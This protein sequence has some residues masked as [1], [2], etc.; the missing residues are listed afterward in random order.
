MTRWGTALSRYARRHPAASDL[1][2][3]L[4]DLGTDGLA[5]LLAAVPCLADAVEGRGPLSPS[6]PF[7]IRGSNPLDRN[8]LAR[9]L[10]TPP[11]TEFLVLSLDASALALAQLA[12]WHGGTL[13]RDLARDEIPTLDADQLD[14]V[15]G[16]LHDRLLTDRDAGWVALR[17]G[18]IDAIDLPGLPAA[19]ALRHVNSDVLADKLRVLG[20]PVPPRKAERIDAV[21][22]A[23]REPETI[24]RTVNRLPAAA[25]RAL[26]VLV[27]HG[28]Q[29]VE[30]LGEPHWPPY[31]YRH[32]RDSAIG[33]LLDR[34]LIGVD[35]DEQTCVVW[36]DVLVGLN[37]GRLF[38]AAFP[39]PAPAAPQAPLPGGP[40]ALPPVLEHLDTLLEHWRVRPAEALSGGGLGVRSVRA[41]AKS[42]GL[43]GPYVGLLAV[44]ATEIGLLGV[45]ERGST[46]RGRDRR[47]HRQWGPTSLVEQWTEQ[48]PAW[49]W[50][51][52]V[53]TWRRSPRV[54]E[55]D[56]LPE[57][58]EPQSVVTDATAVATRSAWL[59]HLA[60]LPDGQGVGAD[61]VAEAAAARFPM[62][63]GA[64]SRV[65]AMVA[66]TRVLGLVPADGPVGLTAAGRAVLDGPDAVEALLPA[67]DD[68][69]IV[70]ADLTIV[71][72]PGAP[73]DVTTA[74]ARWA[75]LE[76]AAGARVYR[77]SE[78]RL[79]AALTTDTE[80]DVL[81][82]LKEHSRV[83]VPQNVEYLIR[84]VARRRGR[85]RAGSTSSYL[86]SDDAALLT[87]AVG[88]RAAK[89]RL[90]A[91]TVAVSPMSRAKLLA[92]LS[93]AGVAAVAEDA[94]GT[95]VQPSAPQAERVGWHHPGAGLPPLR[96]V[97]PPAEIAA[98]LRTDGRQ[99]TLGG[100]GDDRRSRRRDG[101]LD[102][103]DDR[104]RPRRGG[105]RLEDI[106][107]PIERL[108][109]RQLGL[110]DGEGRW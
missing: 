50:A 17:P 62:L 46:G 102:D 55:L 6:W 97:P 105:R 4:R 109:R 92:A 87:Q 64:P 61:D 2:D 69:I 53:Q 52:L 80:D 51:L 5:D 66:A 74:L 43:T 98:R 37:G 7:G 16:V 10:A 32:D 103:T 83:G 88:V 29:R 81:S 58:H 18:V 41:A 85:V 38:G 86:R 34:S 24:E 47:T 31:G 90:L 76:S 57:R 60:A 45:A 42:L 108:R 30:D 13:T 99:Q 9:L 63:L 84:D 54:F 56:G 33:T 91:P 100:T 75:E 101:P 49:R 14:V 68:H 67:P 1:R 96:R 59:L 23:L 19:P 35:T 48:P 27:E 107:D 11:G 44:L 22:E 94:D 40:S 72:P 25:A 78:Q 95:T 93:D 28:P 106:D 39:M 8:G 89:L 77:L 73:P 70:Q 12:V 65:D 110:D 82:W 15:A 20:R 21:V 79:A 36:L 3:E 71:A 26:A 104:H